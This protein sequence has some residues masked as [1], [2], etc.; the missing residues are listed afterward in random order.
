MTT[1][2]QPTTER[3]TTSRDTGMGTG[4]SRSSTAEAIMAALPVPHNLDGGTP[5]YAIERTA[6]IGP[7]A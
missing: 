5:Q 6:G 2:P 3:A 7:I 4:E 1:Q